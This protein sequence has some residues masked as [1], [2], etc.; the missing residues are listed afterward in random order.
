MQKKS[1]FSGRVARLTASG[2][3]GDLGIEPGHAPL[4]T[5][6]KPGEISFTH[7]NG[8]QDHYYVSGGI[9]EVQPDCVTVLADTAERASELD[10]AEALAAKEK[11]QDL[12]AKRGEDFDYAKANAE[13][14]RAMAQLQLI[15][16]LRRNRRM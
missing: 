6:L 4:I 11:A 3:L 1:L 5:I 16:K 14:T 2:G 13:L 9:L 15:Q 7:Q 12:L 10:E 8:E